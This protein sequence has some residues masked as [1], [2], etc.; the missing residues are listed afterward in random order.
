MEYVPQAYITDISFLPDATSGTVQCLTKGN[1]RAEG[2]DYLVAIF[3]NESLVITE[4]KITHMACCS[5]H[6]VTEC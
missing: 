5:H 2:L 4:V 1:E 3:V 6:E